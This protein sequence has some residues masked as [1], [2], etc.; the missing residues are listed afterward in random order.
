MKNTARR[1]KGRFFLPVLF[2][3]SISLSAQDKK[4]TNALRYK[5]NEEGSHFIQFT[6]TNQIW[7][8]YTETNPGSTVD[9][10]GQAAITDIGLRRLRMQLFGQINDRMYFYTQFGMNNYS[11][12]SARH[13]GFFVHDA[14]G[15]YRVAGDHVSIG[16]GL[17][18]WSGL[19]R[20][21]S[22]SVVSILTVDAPLYQQVTNGVN[23]QFLR[24]LSLYAKG[25][26]GPVDYRVAVS[27]PMSIQN[28]ISPIRPLSMVAEFSPKAPELQY[29]GYF[30]YEFFDKESNLNPYAT[31]TYLGSKRVL[32][33]GAGFIQQSNA[34][35]RL[36]ENND[37]LYQ[38]MLLLGIDLFYEAPLNKDKGN[39]LT[40]Y[41]AWN[42]LDLGRNYVRSQGVMNPANGSGFPSFN[43]PGNAFPMVG[44][45]TTLYAQA[46]YL[47]R[48]DLLPADHKL[49]LFAASQ[50]SKFQALADPMLMWEAGANWYVK[51]TVGNK[52]SL[53]YQSR[54]VYEYNS[55]M[56]V[57]ATQRKGMMVLQ[58]QVAI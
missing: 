50:Y 18:G 16:A 15:E 10:N 29:Q 5:L 44:S 25:K 4:Q 37:T 22:P 41:L 20:Y 19:S 2:L 14:L 7:L 28:S 43:G 46:G 31:G 38:D 40:A 21:A 42:S 58:L 23:D 13:A 35:W 52:L 12:L 36:G 47:F 24:K 33:V 57:D 34:M 49:Q 45:G 8:R 32:S 17:T 54:P 39:A 6:L 55:M 26:L 11:Y 30:K 27:K 48:K 56:G 51:G 53:G 1:I 3:L 9:G